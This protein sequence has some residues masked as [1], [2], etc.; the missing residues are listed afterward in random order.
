MAIMGKYYMHY[1]SDFMPPRELGRKN[2]K[3]LEQELILDNLGMCRFHR[4][5][6]EEMIPEIMDSLYGLRDRFMESIRATAGRI[7]SR[8]SSIF[9]ESERCTDIVY[10]F[11]KRK[12]DVEGS[13]DAV[14][15]DWIYRFENNRREAAMEYWYEIHKGIHES[16]GNY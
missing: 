2:A 8:N 4:G 14:L 15:G 3:R 16:F 6:A 5:W 9:W 11:L 10:T 1:G 7:N 13:T 12:R